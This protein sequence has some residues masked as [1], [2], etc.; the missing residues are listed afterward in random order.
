MDAG[1][2]SVLDSYLS[3]LETYRPRV[4]PDSANLAQADALAAKLTALAEQCRDAGEFMTRDGDLFT[5]FSGALTELAKEAFSRPTTSKNFRMPTVKEVAQGYH[6]AYDAMLREYPGEAELRRELGETGPKYPEARKVYERVFALEARA[7]NAAEFLR[8]LAAEGL[9][10]AMTTAPLREKFRPL[11]AHA[12]KVSQPAMAAHNEAMLALL[13]RARSAIEL[14]YE[15]DRLVEL[16]HVE[17][18]WDMQFVSEVFTRVGGAVSAFLMA[19]TEENRARV[20][21]NVRYVAAQFSLAPADIFRVPRIADHIQRILLPALNG[22]GLKY[23][24]ESFVKEQLDT[25]TRCL[26]KRPPVELGPPH[27]NSVVHW[28]KRLPLADVLHTV[29]HPDRPAELER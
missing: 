22:Q 17:K 27:R 23:S 12:E 28:G 29:R 15:S 24:Y 1:V 25:I 21:S 26:A 5:Q 2:Q 3:T 14:E 7:K 8:D 6:A 11:V 16:N 13:D 4:E 10:L 9:L 18:L 20:E 19:S